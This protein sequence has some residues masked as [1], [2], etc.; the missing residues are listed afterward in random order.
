MARRYERFFLARRYGELGTMGKK[1]TGEK[2]RKNTIS[3]I[4]SRQLFAHRA[5]VVFV[6]SR[7]PRTPRRCRWFARRPRPLH[8]VRDIFSPREK[9]RRADFPTSVARA[10][11]PRLRSPGIYGRSSTDAE[12]LFLTA[13]NRPD[14]TGSTNTDRQGHG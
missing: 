8:L 2:Q 3:D 7:F 13:T 11:E 5:A 14:A 4:I 10:N 12:V 9:N 1:E 6:I